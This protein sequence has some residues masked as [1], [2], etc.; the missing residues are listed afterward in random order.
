MIDL[1]FLF[2]RSQTVAKIALNDNEVDV[3]V[4]EKGLRKILAVPRALFGSVAD[5]FLPL[6]NFKSMEKLFLQKLC[7]IE[8]K[9]VEPVCGKCDEGS[10]DLIEKSKARAL[11]SLRQ[12][13]EVSPLLQLLPEKPRGDNSFFPAFRLP[14]LLDFHFRTDWLS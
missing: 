9:V 13:I 4:N 7:D 10:K 6:A 5:I 12:I 3:V 2:C 11:G 8:A 14:D 1:L